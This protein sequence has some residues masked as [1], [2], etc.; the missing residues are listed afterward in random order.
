MKSKRALERGLLAV[1]IMS[2]ATL[3]GTFGILPAAA[4]G[5]YGRGDDY[6]GSRYPARK[7]DNPSGKRDSSGQPRQTRT[8]GAPLLA[9]VALSEQRVSIYNAEGRML[10]SPI[11]SGST[12]YE[13]PAG[14]FSVVQKK[15]E[16]RSNIYE[17]G[18]M[19]F[20][21]RI[22]WT[23]IALH[24]GALPGHPASHGCVRLPHAFAQQLFGLTD[25]GLRVVVVRDDITPAE[26]KHPLL[27]QPSR[28]GQT[29]Q[30]PSGG[31]PVRLASRDHSAAPGSARQ[32]EVLKAESDAK[33]AEADA[34]TKRAA[35]IRR[36]AQRKAAEAA[37]AA[38]Q[39]KA[40]ES[41]LARAENALQDAE[42]SVETAAG[43]PEKPENLQRAE[44]AKAKAAAKVSE[45]RA[46]FEA[47][48]ALA[49]SKGDEAARAEVEVAAADEAREIAAEAASEASLR[50][51]PVSVFISRKTQRLYVRKA[52]QPVYEGPVAIR[53]ADKPL[54]SFVF[55]AL[56]YPDG[57]PDARWSVVS[58][59]K[60]GHETAPAAPAK[61]SRRKGE[62]RTAAEGVTADV[63]SAKAALDRI[64]IPPEAFERIQDVVLPGASLIVSDEG[65]SIETGK[66]TDFVVVMSGEPQGGLKQRKR[67]PRLR[68][69][70]FWGGGGGGFRFFWD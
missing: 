13:T 1:A 40:A 28:R 33:S 59:Y 67:E 55:T 22:T 26:I 70:D 66:D 64:T 19:P 60:A 2:L 61:E 9:V 57:G 68:D 8:G 24:A 30:A 35:E 65:P 34:A 15:E 36:A 14:I 56:N 43:T 44:E 51:S 6:Y 45:A 17:D 52:Y 63:A 5:W 18:N 12:G 47:A 32:I 49:H 46:Q 48:R 37:P 41:N 3:P 7:R 69:D 58:M 50:T 4:Q 20:M 54:G 27:F 11:S 10:H 62:P 38:R 16:H 29:A 23:G 53:D 39:L 42:R 21:Q 25:I 31:G